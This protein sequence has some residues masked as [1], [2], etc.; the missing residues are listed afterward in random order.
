MVGKIIG[1]SRKSF[2]SQIR[3]GGAHDPPVVG[4]TLDAQR[5][6]RQFAIPNGRVLSLPYEINVTIRQ[7]EIDDQFRVFG[8]ERIQ[9][10]NE[11]AAAEVDRR[12]GPQLMTRGSGDQVTLNNGT[13][14]PQLCQR[15]TD[16]SS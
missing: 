8:Q 6:V 3:R 2:A 9:D 1:M 10:R 14:R 13:S 7:V 4:E 16:W 11:I 5:A 12:T 15:C